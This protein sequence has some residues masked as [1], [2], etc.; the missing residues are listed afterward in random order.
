M[1]IDRRELL[2]G[3]GATTAMLCAPGR[4]LAAGN[5]ELDPAAIRSDLDIIE[6]AYGALHPGLDR[7]LG[8]SGFA[9]RI[10]E[11]KRWAGRGQSP[12][13]WFVELGRLTAAVRCGHSFP[14]PV[15][16]RGAVIAAILDGRDRVPFAFRWIGGRMVVTRPLRKGVLLR[17]GQVIEAIDGTAAPELLRRL[18][19]LARADGG[20]DGK[21]VALMQ[22]DGTGRFGAFDVYRPLVSPVRG[23]GQVAVRSGGRTMLLPAMSDAERQA[24]QS[25][26]TDEGGWSFALNDGVGVLT[27]PSWALYNSKWDWRGFLDQTVDRLIDEGA[28]GLVIDLR[29]NEGGLDCGDHLLARLVERPLAMPAFERFV[30]YR[31]VPEALGP[32]LDTWDKSFRDWGEAARASDRPGFFRLVREGEGDGAEVI[33]PKGRRFAGKVAVLISPTCS[34]ATFQFALAIKGKGIARL[35]GTTS[36]GNRRGING[37]AYFFLRLPGT[38]M[39]I[40]LPLIGFF[41]TAAQPD[42]GVEPDILVA[43]SIADIIAG[44]DRAMAA[45]QRSLG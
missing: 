7:Y 39:E 26:K 34:S 43:P 1:R 27:M 38:G 21:R 36:G 22:V 14:N 44:R 10:D 25:G 24:A 8:Q 2:G 15:N 12:R 3:A 16:Q 5:A 23:D 40:D 31:R 41:P 4:L 29:D 33:K 19:P 17:P 30:R 42:A 37:G 28:R 35:V 45:A 9:A 20:N 18:L 32:M 13:A 6:A 11:L